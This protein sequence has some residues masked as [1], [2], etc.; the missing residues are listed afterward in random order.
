VCS[1]LFW[2]VLYY[3]IML[4]LEWV[5]QPSFPFYY[6]VEQCEKH[7]CWFFLLR[8]SRTQQWVTVTRASHCLET[9][10]CFRRI[11]DM[12]LFSCLYPFCS[13]LISNTYKKVHINNTSNTHKKFDKK[14]T[15]R[16]LLD[17]PIFG[18]ISFQNYTPV[19][20]FCISLVTFS[21]LSF[22]IWIL[23]FSLSKSLSQSISFSLSLSLPLSG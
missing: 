5:W 12:D 13:V 15:Y 16:F 23:S 3:G 2:Y 22:K 18:S 20:I 21:A 17:I 14:F 19:M 4:W 11:A 9:F 7:W 8:Y 10:H 6:S 1:F